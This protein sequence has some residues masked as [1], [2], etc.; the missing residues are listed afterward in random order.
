MFAMQSA[1]NFMNS[2]KTSNKAIKCAFFDGARQMIMAHSR[3][4]EYGNFSLRWPAITNSS[5]VIG[6]LVQDESIRGC[7]NVIFAISNL[8][9]DKPCV[10]FMNQDGELVA[11]DLSKELLS[12]LVTKYQLPEDL[13]R[14]IF[15]MCDIADFSSVF[16]A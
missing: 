9:S 8:G 12:D 5:E 10:E 13:A 15:E 11:Q 3:P 7:L 4:E 14:V 2:I 16:R 6:L 1:I